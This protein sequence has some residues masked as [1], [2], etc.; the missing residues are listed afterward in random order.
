MAGSSQCWEPD[1]CPW[2]KYPDSS[3]PGFEHTAFG[4]EL[5]QIKVLIFLTAP[6]TV[7]ETLGH[8]LSLL[9]TASLCTFISLLFY[10]RVLSC[11]VLLIYTFNR[12]L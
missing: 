9:G 5:E 11:T 6:A 10:S 1:A 12:C 3:W 7:L 4:R 8:Q 2:G